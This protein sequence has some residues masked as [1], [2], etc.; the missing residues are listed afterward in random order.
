MTNS[1]S[2]SPTPL[3]PCCG[4][5]IPRVDSK[6]KA[7]GITRFV[8]DLRI[9]GMWYGGLV[10]SPAA[11]GFIGKIEFDSPFDRSSVTIVTAGQIPGKNAIPIIKD[12]MPCLA[13]GRVNYL[14]EPVAL[15]AAP[16]RQTLKSALAA[17]NVEIDA[18]EIPL[19][20]I[21]PLVAAYR[22]DPAALSLLH[23]L[24]IRQGETKKG[25]E[26]ADR[27][28]EGEYWTHP[29]EHAYLET[30]GIIAIPERG[31]LQILGSMQC[32]F[33]VREA[34]AHV[35]GIP[36]NMVRVTQSPTGGA[37]GGKEDYPSLIASHAA[38][39]ATIT[40]KPI[41][42]FL[43][44]E[45]D[46]AFTPKRHASW[47][48]IKTGVL[49]NG[50]LIASEIEFILDGG[51]YTTLTP[52]VLARGAIHVQGAYACPNVS[53]IAR[54]FRT[55]IPPSGAFRGFGGPQ[56]LFAIESHMD[57]LARNLQIDAAELRKR[58]LYRTHDT[59]PF[60]QVLRESVGLG[61]C[62]ETALD[63][64]GYEERR[65]N[66]E[67]R[68]IIDSN[69]KRGL[70]CAVFWHGAGFVGAGEAEMTPHAELRLKTDGYVEIRVSNTELGQGALT[71]LSQIVADACGIAAWRVR[72][73]LP[74]SA[75]APNSGPTVA[76]RTTMIVGKILDRCGLDLVRAVKKRLPALSRREE[77]F[78]VSE[79]DH[80]TWTESA[81]RV[82]QQ[83][84]LHIMGSYKKPD[85]LS[86]D[87]SLN[88]GDAYAAYGWGAVA[89]EIA[90]DMET[91]KITPREIWCAVDVGRAIHPQ[92][93]EAQVEGA[94]I[95]ALGY[96]LSERLTVTEAGAFRQTRFQDYLI[97]TTTE[98]PRLH[99]ALV[100]SPCSHGPHGAKGMGELPMNGLA[101]ALRNAL[102]H[103]LDLPL[104]SIPLDPD[105]VL[106]RF[107]AR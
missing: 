29:Q 52:L 89:T 56:A 38:L 3:Q 44:R 18:D 70:G 77:G 99:V 98:I 64:C 105:K 15:I 40:G 8:S 106:N 63:L 19:I 72:Y 66:I 30:Q 28:V 96:A 97:P 53:I 45:E 1:S 65:R 83:G 67:S 86:W 24:I 47:T 54:A 101:P 85:S 84:P 80:L 4:R 94:L 71:V 12:E 6:D 16:D 34:V 14:G 95:Q 87:A 17:A 107:Q 2:Q 27:I 31:G 48:R 42:L 60:G 23:E 46:M 32:P 91:G 10:R 5:S 13:A 73:P 100:E 41:G 7:R 58:N 69:V 59:T 36:E 57:D 90:V 49:G 21:E 104:N 51:A 79:G 92:A 55:H 37:F 26:Q 88:R 62:M 93:A 68:N 61:K 35:L 75:E 82:L 33:Y 39:L 78:I 102:L 20:G 50:K 43:D 74:D 25:F 81:N 9:P 76:S 103:A 11:S 22:S